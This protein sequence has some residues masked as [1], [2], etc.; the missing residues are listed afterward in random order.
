[1]Y[2]MYTLGLEARHTSEKYVIMKVF[3]RDRANLFRSMLKII[4]FALILQ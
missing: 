4:A 1:M 2:V 3:A